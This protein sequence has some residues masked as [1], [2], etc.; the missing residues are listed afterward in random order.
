V[1]VVTTMFGDG[2]QDHYASLREL[3][4]SEASMSEVLA[5]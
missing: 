1:V 3:V 2:V 4:E 5:E